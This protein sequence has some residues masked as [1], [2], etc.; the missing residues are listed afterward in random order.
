MNYQAIYS[1]LCTRGAKPRSLTGRVE[2]HHITPR[3][4]GGTND[5]S[6]LTT[7]TPREHLLAHRLLHRMHGRWQDGLAVR[8]MAGSC[9]DA[10]SEAQRIAGGLQRDAR[11]GIHKQTPEDHSSLGSRLAA[12]NRE[13]PAGVQRGLDKCHERATQLR[14]ARSKARFHYRDPAGRV[15]ESRVEAAEH[16]GVAAFA[17]ENWGKRNHYG[18]SRFPV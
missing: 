9:P 11:K 5:P 16:H 7:L 12:W 13:N 8:A 4:V 6:N 2:R 15:W 3:H 18:W 14:M 17:V 1:R 10:R